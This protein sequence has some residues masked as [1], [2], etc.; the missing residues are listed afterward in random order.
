M[1]RKG[2]HNYRRD[3]VLEVV[4][5]MQRLDAGLFEVLG[6]EVVDAQSKINVVHFARGFRFA[7]RKIREPR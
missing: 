4:R 2:K 1:K 6:D 3:V 5:D 7:L